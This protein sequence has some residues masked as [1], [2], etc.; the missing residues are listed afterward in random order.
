MSS[1]A[2]QC[3]VDIDDQKSPRQNNGAILDSIASIQL[4]DLTNILA[5]LNKKK[6]DGL[7]SQQHESDETR[8]FGNSISQYSHLQEDGSIAKPLAKRERKPRGLKE[9]KSI[10]LKE[11]K[12]RA[13]KA[14]KDP[15]AKAV[16]K[17]PLTITER[18][19][20]PFLVPET[21][22]PNGLVDQSILD[23]L[24][25]AAAPAALG[26][27]AGKK[28][29]AP[30]K[31]KAKAEPVPVLSTPRTAR[32]KHVCQTLTYSINQVSDLSDSHVLNPSKLISLSKGLFFEGN[33]GLSD[34]L[35]DGGPDKCISNQDAARMDEDRFFDLTMLP[36]R[37][38]QNEEVVEPVQNVNP[39]EDNDGQLGQSSLFQDHDQAG[40][41]QYLEDLV[42]PS[43]DE[44]AGL[45]FPVTPIEMPKNRRADT[46]ES[47][48]EL[49]DSGHFGR[50]ETPDDIINITSSS[51]GPR[52]KRT[53]SPESP[54]KRN[55]SPRTID[56]LTPEQDPSILLVTSSAEAR[57][58][59]DHL[60]GITHQTKT[61]HER[62]GAANTSQ[63]CHGNVIPAMFDSHLPIIDCS[64]GEDLG[65]QPTE[66]II[67][68]DSKQDSGRNG[69]KRGEIS[70]KSE[71]SREDF[72]SLDKMRSKEEVDYWVVP[73]SEDESVATNAQSTTA[74]GSERPTFE[75]YTTARLQVRYHPTFVD[76]LLIRS[77][78]NITLWLQGLK[79]SCWNDRF[80]R[81]MLVCQE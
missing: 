46:V 17:K 71:P 70:S 42:S 33:R 23:F 57:G 77:D 63:K 65:D 8:A 41:E 78:G 34:E 52:T 75:G 28:R 66:L 10:V 27:A 24:A 81:Q 64:H 29:A 38:P 50:E 19:V 12:T 48:R 45:A 21:S 18:A 30:R 26:K 25:P 1:E 53:R 68:L 76:N 67:E 36:S 74:K 51:P 15:A 5:A 14:P 79:K 39:F 3:I 13:V 73:D 55:V 61:A 49:L 31:V 2:Q 6:E 69:T 11:K 54:L 32:R 47:L 58:R 22:K 72:A 16:K 7:D 56:Q 80:T 9:P 20:A 44:R 35:T 59:P 40:L 37:N 43:D 60:Q 62:N 4:P